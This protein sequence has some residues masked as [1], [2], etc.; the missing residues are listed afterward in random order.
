MAPRKKQVRKTTI[1]ANYYNLKN[2][3]SYSSIQNVAKA[4]GQKVEKV[5]DWLKTQDTFTLH[6]PIRHKFRRRRVFA[7]YKNYQWELDLADMIQF[8]PQNNNYRYILTKIDVFSK[9]GAIRP[10]KTKGGEEVAAAIETLLKNEKPSQIC[11]DHGKEF[12]NS[13][14]A[15]LLRNYGIKLFSTQNFEI[16]SS[17]V[18]R[19]N[20]TL[21]TRLFKYFTANNTRKWLIALPQ[22]VKGYNNTYHRSIK[23]TPNSVSEKNKYEVYGNLY[24]GG[25]NS[26]TLS[27]YK[28]GTIVRITKLRTVFG[29]GYIPRWTKEL[30]KIHKVLRTTP[31]TYRLQ[32][33]N[34]DIIDG[35]FYRPEIQPVADKE[36]F[37]INEVLKRRTMNGK[38]EM[39]VSWVNYPDSENMWIPETYIKT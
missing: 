11:T 1:D 31:T 26:K 18:E 32:S 37:E 33:Y 38:K 23:M 28:V 21:K 7:P 14:V 13:H 24:R 3:S 10:L 36:F 5:R 4:S 9:V 16:K 6:K 34:G 20:R 17:V 22:I 15:K 12:Y 19:F 29:K 27:S 39:F 8:K 30:F 2:P 25:M 35:S